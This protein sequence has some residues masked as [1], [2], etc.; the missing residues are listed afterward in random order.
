MMENNTALK[1]LNPDWY[2]TPEGE[3]IVQQLYCPNNNK[4]LKHFG[5]L[6]HPSIAP[7]TQ[8]VVF[9]IGVLGKAGSGK[10][11]TISVL[12]GKPTVFPGYIETIGIHVKNIYWPAQVQAKTCLFK[13]QFW[14]SGESCSKRYNYISTA[15]LEKT[16]A[17][18]I[19][20]NRADRTSLD[21]ADSKL[22]SLTHSVVILFVMDTDQN[23]QIHD[24]E[25]SQYARRRR[26]PFFYLPPHTLDLKYLAPF[27]NSLCDFVFSNQHK[28]ISDSL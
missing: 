6:E 7:G 21:Y 10:T 24:Q 9:K 23:V 14:E 3:L 19:V 26:L 5:I 11:K 27:Y 4:I 22:D 12:S 2:K 18:A 13:L 1:Y 20:V 28:I 8:E 17:V 16:D 25:L 15:C